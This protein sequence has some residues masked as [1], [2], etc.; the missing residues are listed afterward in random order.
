MRERK[1]FVRKTASFEQTTQCSEK[2][3]RCVLGEAGLC[4]K[5]GGAFRLTR[6]R[7]GEET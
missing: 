2:R 1:T 5:E 4:R 7:Q 6:N 3:S